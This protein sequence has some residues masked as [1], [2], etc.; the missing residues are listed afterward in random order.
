[1]KH[2]VYIAFV[3]GVLMPVVGWAQPQNIGKFIR[4]EKS[5]E[6]D[7]PILRPPGRNYKEVNLEAS[8]YI[9]FKQDFSY[10]VLGIEVSSLSVQL[11]KIDLSYRK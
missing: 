6:Y 11:V 10:R 4:S 9:K 7:E 3:L 5:L 2:I 1:M 8:E